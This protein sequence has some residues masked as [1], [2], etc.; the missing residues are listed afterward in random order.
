LGTV[1]PQK[2]TIRRVS[3]FAGALPPPRYAHPACEY[4][5]GSAPCRPPPGTSVGA[6]DS[7]MDS[8]TVAAVRAETPRPG[9]CPSRR[10]IQPAGRAPPSEGPRTCSANQSS[11]HAPTIPP[12]NGPR[13][14]YSLITSRKTETV[15]SDPQ[16]ASPSVHG[17]ANKPGDARH[18]ASLR[19]GALNARGDHCS[20]PSVRM[21]ANKR[22]RYSAPVVAFCRRPPSFVGREICLPYAQNAAVVQ[23]TG[24]RGIVPVP[25]SPV[26]LSRFG[27]RLIRRPGGGRRR[28]SR[29]VGSPPAAFESPCPL[30][31]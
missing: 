23:C 21:P 18:P 26:P 22:G 11:R 30:S 8:S 15:N 27:G 5:R 12:A 16:T 2:C 3:H 7:S 13:S 19:R 17:S 4:E 20:Q 29:P 6:A 28:C 9:S 1:L 14:G 24:L 10:P 25:L 31:P